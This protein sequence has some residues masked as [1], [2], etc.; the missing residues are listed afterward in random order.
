MIYKHVEKERM[1]FRIVILLYIYF[2]DGNFFIGILCT[3]YDN[4]FKHLLIDIFTLHWVY[5]LRQRVQRFVDR[6][7]DIDR[8]QSELGWEDVIWSNAAHSF[9]WKGYFELMQEA[10][11]ALN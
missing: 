1:I 10:L 2:W 7:F 8:R 3:N 5:K 9:K 4:V 11:R 6:Y